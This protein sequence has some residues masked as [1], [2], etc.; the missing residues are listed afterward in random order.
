M[1]DTKQFILPIKKSS[2]FF[3]VIR[4]L[5]TA[6]EA[7]NN[8]APFFVMNM[9]L[10]TIVVKNWYSKMPN[11]EPFYPIRCNSDHVFLKLLTHNGEMGL[12]CSNREEAEIVPNLIS[13]D[14]IIYH[15]PLWTRGNIRHAR[16]CGIKTFIV[17]SEDDLRRFTTFYPDANIILRVVMDQKLISDPLT[18][19]NFNVERAAHLL[20]KT[21]NSSLNISVRS[22]GPSP[23]MYSYAIAQCRRLFDIG[24]EFGHKFCILDLGEQFPSITATS[25]LSFDQVA[26]SVRVSLSL[27]FP[28]KLFKHVKIIARP[29][30]YFA[31]SSCSF[32]TRIIGKQVVDSSILTNYGNCCSNADSTAY[33]YQINEGFY[34]AFG[35]KLLTHCDPT[36]SPLI[37]D[38]GKLDTFAAI[39]GPDPCHNDVVLPLTRLP[40]LQVNDWLIWHDMGAY[41]MGNC[42]TL[43]G[44]N[45]PLPTIHYYWESDTTTFVF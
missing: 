31:A 2:D 20:S 43:N 36:C 38:G 1:E 25:G 10:I 41:T 18:A 16:E 6:K 13:V 19:D 30:T 32:V 12:C 15:N 45:I 11:I 4:K 44:E 33:I 8:N 14:R 3:D 39:V 29:G 27:L 23:T 42:S 34:G 17:E 7:Q 28:S 35:C 37:D 21:E 22:N 9:R 5:I 40:V 26:D 24:S